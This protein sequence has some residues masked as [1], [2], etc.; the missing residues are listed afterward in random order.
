MTFEDWFNDTGKD[1][2]ERSFSEIAWEGGPHKG[3]DVA[4]WLEIAFEE[5]YNA[6]RDDWG[7]LDHNDFDNDPT[8]VWNTES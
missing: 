3:R 7:A 8:K 4:K 2:N 1:G 5:G 6:G